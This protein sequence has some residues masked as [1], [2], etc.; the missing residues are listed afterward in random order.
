MS[1]S[2]LE[3]DKIKQKISEL[4]KKKS[5]SAEEINTI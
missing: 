3:I 2:L 1:E 5:L 4:R